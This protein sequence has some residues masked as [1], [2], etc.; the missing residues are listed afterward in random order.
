MPDRPDLTPL[1]ASLFQR[2]PPPKTRM[3]GSAELAASRGPNGAET[4]EQRSP[5]YSPADYSGTE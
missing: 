4:G 3:L 5:T 2:E 1:V